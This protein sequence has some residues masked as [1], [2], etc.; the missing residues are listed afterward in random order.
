MIGA[1]RAA[2]KITDVRVRLMQEV[3]N[4]IKLIVLFEWRTPYVER[5]V[6][7]RKNELVHVR[8]LA[9][10]RAFTFS[11]VY[12][13]PVLAAVLSFITYSLLGHSLNPAIIFSS[14]QYLN[15][16]RMPLVMVPLVASSLGDAYVALG[17]IS[18][19][20]LAEEIGD[21]YP[22]EGDSD[23]AVQMRGEFTWESAGPP[24]QGPQGGKGKGKGKGPGKGKDGVPENKEEA[25]KKKAEAKLKKKTEKMDAKAEKRKW[26]ERRKRYE[27]GEEVESDDEAQKP[28]L[29]ESEAQP[30]RLRDVDFNVP[31]GAFVAICGK[32]GSGKSRYVV[33]R[34]V[35]SA[36]CNACLSYSAC[37]VSPACCK[38][39]QARCARSVA[40][41]PS[42]VPWATS[43]KRLGSRT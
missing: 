28:Q 21:D 30:F 22:I 25:K 33:S 4:G 2:V 31:K 3:F 1:R 5:I 6:G 40:R 24:S 11:I 26:Q 29:Q 23:W 13:I 36:A 42:E 14:L 9:L 16:V 18:K 32:V 37:F 38:L 43:R 15:I 27:A 39:W 17:R 10:Y 19:V 12:F 34:S 20:L 41:L 7:L 8:K 35:C